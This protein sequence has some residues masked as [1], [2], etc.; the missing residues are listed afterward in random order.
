MRKLSPNFSNN[1]SLLGMRLQLPWHIGGD[2]YTVAEVIRRN[3]SLVTRAAHFVT[4][5]RLR[6]CAEAAELVHSNP[7]LVEKV[8]ELASVDE[9]DA[10][11]RIKTSLR[12]FSELNDFMRLAGVVKY[13]VTCHSRDDGQKQLV[14]IGRDCWLCIRQYLKAG[15]I[16]DEQ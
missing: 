6:Y 2:W 1:Y 16:L 14:D 12:S 10:A 9:N 8:Q 4:G 13:G 7:G 15:D 11:L 5:R 3:C